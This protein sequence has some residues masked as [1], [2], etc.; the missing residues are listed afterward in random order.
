M[1]SDRCP[2]APCVVSHLVNEIGGTNVSLQERIFLS[3]GRWKP[4]LQN[5]GYLFLTSPGEVGT[6][7]YSES[8]QLPRN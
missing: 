4:H 1:F 6:F 5:E 2:S 7:G 8:D 3:G